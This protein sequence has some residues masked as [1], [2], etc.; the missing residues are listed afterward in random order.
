MV[1]AP[2]VIWTLNRDKHLARCIESLK[3]SRY[4][5]DTELFISIDYPPDSKY[6]EGYKKVKAYLSNELTGF[7]KINTFYQEANL[8]PSENCNFII[9]KAFC[10]YD[11]L[12]M[13]EDDN[14]FSP[15]FLEYMDY[16]LD[17]YE[18]N[19]DIFAIGG[20]SY[21]VCWENDGKDLVKVN[22]IF[23]AWGSGLWLK[24]YKKC[25]DCLKSKNI[26]RLMKSSKQV[27]HIYQN[28]TKIFCNL[29]HS[30]LSG[31]G[32]MSGKNGDFSPEDI[33]LGMYLIWSRQYFIIP[34]I[35]QVINHGY[36]GTGVHCTIDYKEE[37]KNISIIEK[38]EHNIP[39]NIEDN[40]EF[41]KK[42]SR[43][44]AK[45]NASG[46]LDVSSNWFQYIMFRLYIKK[47]KA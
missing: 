5:K 23:S 2:V 47:R 8:G 46:W 3:K 32:I 10:L 25:L 39:L 29:I 30:Y 31:N 22:N 6:E 24:K 1:Y 27:F 17:R 37:I 33:T 15:F 35:P 26:E 20:Y 18:N 38:W 36:D 34:K 40:I 7:K 44:I 45:K 9:N 43:R 21:P 11:R 13:T 28:S 4:A 12:I 42:N 19:K 16:M 14:E 41:Y